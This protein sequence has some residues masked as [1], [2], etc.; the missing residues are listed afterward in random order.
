MP[1]MDWTGSNCGEVTDET[2][3][4]TVTI[5]E[6]QGRYQENHKQDRGALEEIH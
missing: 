5:S 3:I 1:M 2:V 4:A 6:I